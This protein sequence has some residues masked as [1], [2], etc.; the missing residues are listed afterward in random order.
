MLLA[1]EAPR[2]KSKE[3]MDSLG[4]AIYTTGGKCC[5]SSDHQPV[6]VEVGGMSQ[7]QRDAALATIFGSDAVRAA[8]S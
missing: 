5:H 8:I 7:Q 3:L 4:I 1:L 6:L 2:K